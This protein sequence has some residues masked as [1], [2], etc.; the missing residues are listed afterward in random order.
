MWLSQIAHFFGFGCTM[1][2]IMACQVYPDSRIIQSTNEREKKKIFFYDHLKNIAKCKSSSSFE[3]SNIGAH[4][5]STWCRLQYFFSLINF[6]N[7]T[8]RADRQV[9]NVLHIQLSNISTYMYTRFPR[10]S[11]FHSN[12]PNKKN[13]LY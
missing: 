3:I 12:F 8:F 9:Q 11:T 2:N 13:P 4:T 7:C 5:R 10:S 1:K 6:Y